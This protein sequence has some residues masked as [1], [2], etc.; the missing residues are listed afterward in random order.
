MQFIERLRH[1]QL[2]DPKSSLGVLCSQ[3]EPFV[4]VHFDTYFEFS[5]FEKNYFITMLQ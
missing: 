5:A 4:P 2:L 3:S 1:L